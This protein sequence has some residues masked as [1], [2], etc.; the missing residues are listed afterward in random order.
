MATKIGEE[1]CCPFCGVKFV[2][3]TPSQKYCTKK[4]W[5]RERERLLYKQV[6]NNIGGR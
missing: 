1:L 4:C 2:K 5:G 3:K 6:S